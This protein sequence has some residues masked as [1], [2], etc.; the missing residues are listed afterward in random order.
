LIILSLGWI[1]LAPFGL[2]Y[3]PQ[4]PLPSTK[5]WYWVFTVFSLIVFMMVLGY[6]RNGRFLGVLIDERNKMTL[7]R[8]Q[9]IIWSVIVLSGW[10]TA[11]LW[12]LLAIGGGDALA[13][14]LPEELWW[15]LGISTTSLVGSP[16]ILLPK[17]GK[18][19]NTAEQLSNGVVSSVGQ[20][21]VN[22][23]PQEAR[24]TDMFTGDE[25]GNDPSLDISKVQ[26]FF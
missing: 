15:L 12:N 14:G 16:L 20:V 23:T 22:P 3:F 5:F 13:V 9:L 26:L 10:G 6:L 18:E 4:E 8:L 25:V 2:W 7:S 24:P 17:K 19:A 21:A 1:I 11:A